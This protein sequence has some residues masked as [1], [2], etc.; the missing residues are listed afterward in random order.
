MVTNGKTEYLLS[1]LD[2]LKIKKGVFKEI[3]SKVKH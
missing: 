2:V 1:R 3:I